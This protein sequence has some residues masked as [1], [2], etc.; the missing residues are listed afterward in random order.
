MRTCADWEKKPICA[1]NLAEDPLSLA[2]LSVLILSLPN[3][4]KVPNK[5]R[6]EENRVDGW[7]DRRDGGPFRRFHLRA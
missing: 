7:R 5:A 2:Q 4:K 1:L 6:Q 3:Q